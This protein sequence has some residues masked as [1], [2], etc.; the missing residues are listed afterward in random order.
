VFGLFQAPYYAYSQTMMAELTPP[1][2]ENMVCYP[3]SPPLTHPRLNPLDQ[4]FG[5]FGLA[6]RA[7]SVIGPLVLQAIV[8]GGKE[9]VGFGVLVGVCV[10][11]G[12][13]V[14]W[15]VDVERGRVDAGRWKG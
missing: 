12:A 5:L 10:G 7:S 13:V 11:A 9:R 15:G 3:T 2:S 1:G 14:G 6:N 4:F 8:D